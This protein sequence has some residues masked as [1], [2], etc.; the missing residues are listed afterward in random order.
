[1]LA[2]RRTKIV[3]TI[4][5]ATSSELAL[6]KLIRSGMNVARLNFSHGQHKDHLAN[7]ENIRKLSSRLKAPVALLQDLQGPKIRIGKLKG[8]SVE[9]QAGDEVKISAGIEFGTA[10]VLSTDFKELPSV[11]K[12]GTKI[13]LDDGK[14]ELKVIKVEGPEVTCRVIFGGILTDRKGMN[15]PGAQLPVDGMTEKDLEDLEFGLHHNVDYV[16]LSFVRQASDIRKLRELIEAKRPGTKIIAKIEM[17][18]A[19][20]NLTEIIMA[21][22]AVMVARGDLMVEVGA[23]QL[24][25]AQKRIIALCNEIGRPVITATQMLDSMVDSP[26]PTR[27]EITDV[28][29]AVLD[30]SDA[31]MLSAETASGKYPF[32]CVETMHEIITEVERTS[33]NYY[34]FG[35]QSELV[36]TAEAIGASASLCAMNLDAKVIVCL[37]TTGR[38][39]RLIS[40]VR[41]KAQVIAC[42]YQVEALNRLE[43][44]WGVQTLQIN[45][46]QSSEEAMRQIQQQLLDFGI[47]E[48]G[49]RVILTFGMPV[50]QGAKT[51][52]LRVFVIPDREKQE[53]SENDK[54]LRWQNLSKD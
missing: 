30:G 5:P 35:S 42:T 34:D 18:E 54:P 45:P 12:P 51:N 14:L 46:Y 24:P 7:I 25:L 15:L 44:V 47:V 28:A 21:S 32:K 37:T 41:P 31:L 36:D 23:A 3:A 40:H 38:T 20:E 50:Q 19:L 49:D 16:A 2:Q 11:C 48:P 8:G 4:G 10:K 1:M 9:L 39:A 52:S 27:A 22:D 13:L 26:A 6:E 53:L 33:T 43:L 29:N 17:F